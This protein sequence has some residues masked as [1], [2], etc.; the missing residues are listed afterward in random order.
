[1]QKIAL[2]IIGDE[3]LKGSV[4]DANTSFLGQFLGK[5]GHKLAAM[6][7]CSDGIENIQKALTFLE[8][9]G[10]NIIL[11]SGGLGPTLD[12]VTK[13]SV[14]LWINPQGQLRPHQEARAY[15]EKHYARLGRAYNEQTSYHL[16]P[17]GLTPLF[18]PAGLAPGLTGQKNQVRVYCAP[19]VPREF[20]LMISDVIAPHL[21]WVKEETRQLTFRTTGLPEEKIFFELCPT[22]WEELEH[23]GSVSSLPSLGGV[24]I[25]VYLHNPADREKVQALMAQTPLLE[26]IWEVG[27]RDFPEVLIDL[28]TQKKKTL[29]LAESCTGGLV[30]HHFT[31]ISGASHIFRGGVVSY[32][33]EIK[34]DLLGVSEDLLKKHGAVSAEVASAMAQGALHFL[35]SDVALAFTGIAGP[36]GGTPTKP[37]GLVWI[38]L[39]TREGKVLVKDF[40]FPSSDRESLK[41]RFMRAGLAL[42]WREFKASFAL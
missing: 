17:E 38:A 16:I 31:N 34:T 36:T 30:A 22:L 10:A 19:G 21:G 25:G 12:D 11:V 9:Q 13:K 4:Q 40:T 29:A 37:V 20:R 15:L 8:Q 23:Y 35:K 32:D 26:A 14:G 39:A 3:I 18:N 1:M 33:N 7:T 28:F 5:R 41:F 24:D 6:L 42:L 27:S 2:L